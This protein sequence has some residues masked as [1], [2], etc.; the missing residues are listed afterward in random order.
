LVFSSL[1]RRWEDIAPPELAPLVQRERMASYLEEDGIVIIDYDLTAHHV[2]LTTHQLR[3]FVGSCTYQL[4][5]PDEPTSPD[6]PL[7]V[8]QQFYLL[9]L[10]AFYSGVGHKTTMGLGQVRLSPCAGAFRNERT[11]KA[12]S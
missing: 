3:G 8:R 7:T 1:R 12:L 10:L 6:A 2:H 5:G 11:R 9:A 4:R